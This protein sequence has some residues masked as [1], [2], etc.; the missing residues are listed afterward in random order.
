ME[1][2]GNKYHT[3]FCH[4]KIPISYS[5]NFTRLPDTEEAILL[6]WQQKGTVLLYPWG[7][8]TSKASNK[9]MVEQEP[10]PSLTV[11]LCTELTWC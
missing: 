2:R 1:Y 11:L 7:M 10:F 8:N 5:R 9:H 4:T 3:S 6:C